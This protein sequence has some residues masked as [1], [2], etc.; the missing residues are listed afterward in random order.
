MEFLNSFS[1]RI[2]RY[3]KIDHGIV[4]YD[5]PQ[6]KEIEPV[7]IRIENSESENDWETVVHHQPT[8]SGTIN[9]LDEIPQYKYNDQHHLVIINLQTTKMDIR[10]IT[11]TTMEG[12][13]AEK[14]ISHRLNSIQVVGKFCA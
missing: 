4:I 12:T 10:Y 13:C 14:Y 1:Y 9:D 11:K 5:I 8:G 3:Q 6:D 2:Q 7:Q